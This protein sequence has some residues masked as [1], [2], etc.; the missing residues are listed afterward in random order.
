M[1]TFTP[2][3][4]LTAFLSFVLALLSLN[5]HADCN[6]TIN[7]DDSSRVVIRV[8]YATVSGIKTGA[9]QITVPQY[10]SLQIEATSGNYLTSVVK[11][12]TS[13]SV[14]Q[15]ITSLT[16]CNIYL[17]EPADEGAVINVLSANLDEARTA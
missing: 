4:I 3:R 16:S 5:A 7:V 1:H 10:G 11:T 6:V 13:G 9:N 2:R 8:N 15:G 12:N 17:S 14:S